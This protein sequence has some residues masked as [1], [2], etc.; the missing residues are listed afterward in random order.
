MRRALVPVHAGVLSAL[1]M[2]VT[3][4]GRLLTRTWL[5]A[6]E[7]LDDAEVN[8]QIEAL[9]EQGAASLAAEGVERGHLEAVFTL[10]MRYRGQAYTLN[11]PWLGTSATLGAFH[12]RHEQRY[13]HH[14]DLAVELV[15][16]RVSLAAPA[17]AV[18]LA[19]AP[20]EATPMG[21]AQVHGC[22]IPVPL[23]DRIALSVGAPLRGPAVITD[24]DATTWLAPGWIARRD[25]TGNVQLERD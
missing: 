19:A 15:N 8:R 18:T 5:C 24:A 3:R 20:S 14:L 10:D 13:G 11:V 2:L 23:V 16:L 17:P 21:E 6:L 9:A 12:A 7:T 25:G 1:G 4:P 22:S